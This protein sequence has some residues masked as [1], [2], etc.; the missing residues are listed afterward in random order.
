MVLEDVHQLILFLSL[1]QI[2][3]DSMNILVKA[4]T[5]NGPGEVMVSAR[6]PATTDTTRVARAGNLAS[7]GA[8][9]IID[10]V[11]LPPAA[12]VASKPNI[13]EFAESVPALA[14]L[15][16]AVVAGDLAG[17]MSSPGPFTVFA[18]TNDA[19]AALPAG[20]VD[21]LLKAENKDELVDLL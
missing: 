4:N 11:L 16:S 1:H 21:N 8:A 14:T 10:E 19:F 6:S 13:V 15:V 18:P 7:N 12:L 20:V 2:V 9:H 3:N 17:T 5:M